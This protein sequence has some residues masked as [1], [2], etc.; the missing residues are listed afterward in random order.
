MPPD[1]DR[2]LTD[3]RA[4]PHDHAVRHE[5]RHIARPRDLATAARATSRAGDVRHRGFRV[6]RGC[7]NDRGGPRHG[8]VPVEPCAKGAHHVD[9]KRL[10]SERFGIGS[11]CW[12]Q[13]RRI[14][15]PDPRRKFGT[16]TS[17]RTP[18]A[19]GCIRLAL[20]PRADAAC[21]NLYTFAHKKD[22]GDGERLTPDRDRRSEISAAE[23][24][25]LEAHGSTG[26][27]SSLPQG[28]RQHRR[29]GGARSVRACAQGR[30]TARQRGHAAGLPG[31]AHRLFLGDG[32]AD[33]G[34]VPRHSPQHPRFLHARPRG[35]TGGEN[36]GGLPG[37][38]RAGRLRRAA[39]TS[40]PSGRKRATCSTCDPTSR[41]N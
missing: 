36:D 30:G 29:R 34:G 40:S 21:Y 39:A 1:R 17:H 28:N 18:T 7:R 20:A 2:R 9:P 16:L 37:G 22:S 33:A 35:R 3:F 32:P 6:S 31:L 13:A 19:A 25:A 14:A 26:F 24:A 15:R 5:L 10:L 4:S 38:P 12:L 11:H 8:Q 23:A 41:P 27:A